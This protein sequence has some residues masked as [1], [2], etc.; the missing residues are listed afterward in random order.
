M[1]PLARIL[2]LSLL[3]AALLAGCGSNGSSD[4][5]AQSGS[6]TTQAQESD[7]GSASGPVGVRA[8]SCKGGDGYQLLR[9]TGVDC[10]TGARVASGWSGDSSCRPPNGQSRSTC[11]V[12]EYRC[13][14][15]TVD[16]G[17]AVSCARPERAIAFIAAR[18][19]G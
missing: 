13:L 11:A 10:A 3:G 12:G 8:R 18:G 19:R 7:S 14:A 5:T 4:S 17:L 1:P 15:A 2:L 6:E 16:R 9:V